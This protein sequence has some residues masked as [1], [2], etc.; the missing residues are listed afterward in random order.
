MMK[1]I[2]KYSG[3]FVRYVMCILMMVAC[4]SFEI[5]DVRASSTNTLRNLRSE[6]AALEAQYKKN[7]SDKSSTQSEINAN[8]TAIDNAKN[9]ITASQNKVVE[10]KAKIEE[11]NVK[12][13]ETEESNKE[14]MKYFQLMQGDNIYLQFA[15]DASS[16]TELIMRVDAINKLIEYQQDK[17]NEFDDLIKENEQLQVDLKNYE[18]EL[19]QNIVSYES[20]ILTL[21]DDLAEL[22]EIGMD[23]YDEIRSK[24]ELIQAYV[25]MGCGEDDDLDVCSAS[26]GNAQWLKP[27]NK[28][29]VNSIFGSRVS[30]I[31]GVTSVHKAVDIGGNAEGTSVYSVGNGIVIATVDGPATMKRTGK[32]TCGGSQVYIQLTVQGKTYVVQYCHLLKVFVSVGDKVTAN[33][34]IGQQGGGSG[35]SSW[36][37]CSTGTHL[38][39]GVAEGSPSKNQSVTS[40]YSAHAIYPPGYPSKGSWFY[41]RTQYFS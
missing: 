5:V 7:N 31:T 35:T 21:Q 23:L 2:R 16:M 19:E 12:I 15:T 25:D 1:V 9:E 34:V 20:K 13:T 3:Y 24:K 17:L 33:T 27:L 29:R 30:P 4:F 18:E 14:L 32:K 6:L 39:F 38:H 28:G 41:S 22:N 11:T 36:D 10:A 8:S 26:A 37:Y 40:Y